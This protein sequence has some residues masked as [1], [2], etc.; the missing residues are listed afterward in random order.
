[1]YQIALFGKIKMKLIAEAS[2][3]KSSINKR[4]KS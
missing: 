3:D 1:M 4:R 2:E